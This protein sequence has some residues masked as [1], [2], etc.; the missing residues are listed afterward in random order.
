MSVLALH[1]AAHS[2]WLGCTAGEGLNPARLATRQSSAAKDGLEPRG[3][4][5]AAAVRHGLGRSRPAA[6]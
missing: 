5:G 2:P 3:R 6:P 4:G 1:Q